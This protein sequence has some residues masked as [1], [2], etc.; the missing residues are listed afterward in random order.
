M[1]QCRS[2]RFWPEIKYLQKNGG[3]EK[4]IWGVPPSQ[5]STDALGGWE[6][7]GAALSR[8][9]LCATWAA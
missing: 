1:S 3:K 7:L 4:Y 2:G 8:S 5:F 6:A 9:A